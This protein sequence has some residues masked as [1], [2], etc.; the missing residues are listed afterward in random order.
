MLRA[1]WITAVVFIIP[2]AA[3]GCAKEYLRGPEKTTI[4]VPQK[5]WEIRFESP[6]L[7]KKEESRGEDGYTFRGSSGR[8]TISFFV[9]QPQGDG[10]T[11]KDSYNFYW[12]PTSQNALIVKDSVVTSE[13]PKYIRVQ[14]IMVVEIVGRAYRQMHVHYYF[15]HGGNWS[16]VH[17]SVPENTQEDKEVLEVFDKTFQYGFTQ[18]ESAPASAVRSFP[19]PNHG[20]LVLAVPPSWMDVVHQPPDDLPPTLLFSP[21][22]GNRFELLMT[23]FWNMKPGENMT[24]PGR[25]KGMVTAQGQ[26]HLSAAIERELTVLQLRRGETVGYYYV[27]TDKVSEPGGFPYRAQGAIG[28]G[29]LLLS[30]TLL[31]KDKDSDELQ[32]PLDMLIN[33][34]YKR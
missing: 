28:M 26:T 16:E 2:L 10:T 25:L 32:A 4:Q 33:A 27:L 21:K 18:S 1:V 24:D 11:N 23:V 13:T 17:I 14:Y 5:G 6:P 19:V 9:K 29:D 31:F 30:F 34:K 7:A 3:M 20:V 8:F 12:Q 22:T 15:A